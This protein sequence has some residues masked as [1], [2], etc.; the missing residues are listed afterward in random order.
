MTVTNLFERRMKAKG[1]SGGEAVRN[2]TYAIEQKTFRN[3]PSWRDAKL[4]DCNMKLLEEHVDIKFK[5][6]QSYTINKDQVEWLVRFRPDFFPEKKYIQADN[7]ERMGFYLE[8]DDA[9]SGAIEKW[10]LLGRNDKD[11]FVSYN[12]LKCNW[13]FKWIVDGIIYE[14]LGCVRDRNNY[15]SGVWSDGFVTS[16]EDQSLFIVPT[17]NITMTIDYDTRFMLSDNHINPTTYEVSKLNDVVPMGVSKITLKQDHYN[18]VRDNIELKICDYYT[19]VSPVPESNN[20]NQLRLKYSGISPTLTIG[21][22]KRIIEIENASD[23]E[24]Y[25]WD[26]YLDGN[27]LDSH[28]LM[29][30]FICT[31]SNER[32]VIRTLTD[33]TLIGKILKIVVTNIVG[34]SA[35]I[36]LEVVR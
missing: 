19:P 15:N 6:S 5:Y 20:R 4:Y 28:K 36:E 18:R 25:T 3:V 8:F 26:F 9:K 23:S 35:F 11:I 14:S 12:V 7:I 22:S 31:L 34:D 27:F 13:T 33:Y 29:E 2:G 10:L 16:V 32:V 24:V 17:N 21:G 1:R 30:Y